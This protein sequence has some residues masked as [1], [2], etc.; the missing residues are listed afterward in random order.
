MP[1]SFLSDIE[2]WRYVVRDQVDD[3]NHWRLKPSD[4]RLDLYFSPNREQF[5][6]IVDDLP[7]LTKRLVEV[8]TTKYPKLDPAPILILHDAIRSW[9]ANKDADGI[10]PKEALFAILESGLIVV[11]AVEQ[12]FIQRGCSNP[13]TGWKDDVAKSEAPG[14][15]AANTGGE[16]GAKGAAWERLTVRCQGTSADVATLDGKTY[17]LRG[18]NDSTL[19]TKLKDAQGMPCSAAVLETEIGE[20]PSAI[21][22][23]LPDALQR[24]IERP[25]RGA[26]T[27]YRML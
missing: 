6:E 8:I 20:K 17:P 22:R 5:A 15:G 26:R 13:W 25:E 11:S 18:R 23:R 27:G 9:H 21:Y 24:I 3:I 16:A 19:L 10:P 1:N 14:K 12:D 4:D 2:W 7:I